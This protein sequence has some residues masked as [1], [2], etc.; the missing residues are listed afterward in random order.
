MSER[1]QA[2]ALKLLREWLALMRPIADVLDVAEV[3]L[4]ERTDKFL[5][6]STPEPE[7]H[8]NRRG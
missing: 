3:D 2:A 5:A 1:E 7:S 8:G 4:I 6:L